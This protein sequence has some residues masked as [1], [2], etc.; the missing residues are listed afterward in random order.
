[1]AGEKEQFRFAET[2]RILLEQVIAPAA[3][4]GSIL[5]IGCGEGHQ[6]EHLLRLCQ[7]LT[8]V[9]V[10]ATAVERARARLP[11]RARAEFLVGD[12]HSQPWTAERGQFDVVTAFEVIYY[13][14]DIPEALAAMSSLGR[15][16][17]ITYHRPAVPLLEG[18]L[19][20]LPIAGR[21][22][23]TFG[24]TEWRAAWWFSGAS[25]T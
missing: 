22:T 15:A 16:C 3:R 14:K 13:Y 12:L 20:A 4:A 25:R 23:I 11:D 5:E 1:M 7:R 8:G 19:R 21:A 17:M 24:D 9:D 6:S 2:N 10:V 18:P